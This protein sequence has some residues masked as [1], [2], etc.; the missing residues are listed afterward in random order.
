MA[1]LTRATSGGP[2]P[3]DVHNRDLDRPTD[4]EPEVLVLI[5]QGLSN[6]EIAA[7]LRVGESTVKTHVK[8][9]LVKL[10]L[11]DRVHAVVFAYETGLLSPG[12][13]DRR[14]PPDGDV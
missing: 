5:A 9:I 7:D 3:T 2:R 1:E 8:R 6:R 14:R 12:G 11:R 10:A 4:R 13:I